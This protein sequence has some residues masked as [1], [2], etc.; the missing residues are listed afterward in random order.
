MDFKGLL[1]LDRSSGGR[2]TDP[3]TLLLNHPSILDAFESVTYTPHLDHALKS[4]RGRKIPPVV[5]IGPGF[6]ATYS[7]KT[8]T[9]FKLFAAVG[10]PD[11]KMVVIHEEPY[12]QPLRCEYRGKLVNETIPSVVFRAAGL[13]PF[14][15]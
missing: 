8:K 12:G 2:R 7:Q 3:Y 11:D 13:Q 10:V 4:I 5:V 1:V 9:L 15:G 6:L 14:P